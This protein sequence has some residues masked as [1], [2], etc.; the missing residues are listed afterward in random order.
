MKTVEEISG[1][2]VHHMTGAGRTASRFAK[3]WNPLFSEYNAEK[4]VVGI[5][6]DGRLDSIRA[7]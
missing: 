2:L 6:P 3:G 7:Y 5:K 1:P 4:I